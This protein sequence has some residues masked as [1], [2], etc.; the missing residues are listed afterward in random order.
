[1]NWPLKLQK[2]RYLCVLAFTSVLKCKTGY[3][4]HESIEVHKDEITV[5]TIAIIFITGSRRELLSLGA[6]HLPDEVFSLAIVEG[7]LG[8]WMFNS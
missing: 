7:M 5:E 1:M 6:N 2:K 3:V 4:F 8:V